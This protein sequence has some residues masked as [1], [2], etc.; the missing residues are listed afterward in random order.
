[1]SPDVLARVKQAA[2]EL[3]YRPNRLARG[4]RPQR[5]HT[6]ALIVPDIANPFYPAV[7]MPVVRAYVVPGFACLGCPIFAS[8]HGG[9]M[10]GAPVRA[11]VRQR[12]LVRLG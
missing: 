10:H 12:T 2:E 3:G 4:L 8:S 7:Q 11:C 1:V 5:T 6:L 9:H